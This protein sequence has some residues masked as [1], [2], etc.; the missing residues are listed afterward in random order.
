LDAV[1]STTLKPGDQ[2]DPTLVA[3]VEELEQLQPEVRVYQYSDL[4]GLS[5]ESAYG[6][7][8]RLGKERDIVNRLSVVYALTDYFLSQG[9]VPTFVDVRYPEA[10]YYGE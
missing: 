1:G 10:P 6:W 3:A 9:I 4:Y 2:L 5:F 8:V 7:S